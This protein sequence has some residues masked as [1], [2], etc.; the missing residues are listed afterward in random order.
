[1]IV[2]VMVMVICNCFVDISPLSVHI[3]KKYIK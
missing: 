1:M 3:R 2:I